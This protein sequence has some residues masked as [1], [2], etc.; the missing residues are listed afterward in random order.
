MRALKIAR[1]VTELAQNRLADSSYAELRLV[2]CRFH[3][4]VLTLRGRVPSFYLK[5]VAQTLVRDIPEATRIDNR[6]EVIVAA[7]DN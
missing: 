4:G 3:E 2:T 7:N 1:R 5:Q 6:I